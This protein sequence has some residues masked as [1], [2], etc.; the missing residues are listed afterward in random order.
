VDAI[1]LSHAHLDHAGRLPLLV[2]KGYAGPIY[3]LPATQDLARYL[4]TDA[5]KLQAEDYQRD[6][7]KGREGAQPLFDEDD[8]EATL[9][10]FEPIE[11]GREVTVAGAR[12]T[13]QIA[14]HIPGSAS[15]LLEANGTRLVF[16]GDLGN[17]RKEVLPDPLPCPPA[18]LVLMESTYGDRDHKPYE[19]SVQE[20]AA[21]IRDASE[22]EGKIL[23][24]SFALE[25]TQDL[26]YQIR[27]LEAAGKIPVL[28]VFV[29]SPLATRVGEVYG[30]WRDEFSPEVQAVYDS[31]K[32]PFETRDLRYTRSVEESKALNEMRGAA[33]II[34]G[35]G[36]LTGGRILH[37]LRNHLPKSSTTLLIVGFQPR[38]GL[39]RRLIDGADA[40]RVMGKDV[41]V[42]ATVAT[43]GGFSAH[44]DRSELLA[45]AAGAGRS[46]QIR[47]VHGEPEAGESLAAALESRGQRAGLQPPAIRLPSDDDENYG[48]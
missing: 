37:H 43:I 16:S 39:G 28:P 42:N 38:G 31:G 48:E 5:A 44:G 15:F 7:R 40:V 11:F 8:V 21:A 2:R 32:D 33:I 9:S 19:L 22:R 3:A 34:A 25:R 36:M 23:I 13:A 12:V 20:L 18:D 41:R 35:A 10:L 14:A 1:L 46:A 4:L 17:S 27:K 6:L 26:L 45:W 29:D 30:R 47:L 24:P